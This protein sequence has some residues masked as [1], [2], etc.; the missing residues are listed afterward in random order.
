M[1]THHY[2]YRPSHH[3]KLRSK[4][5]CKFTIWLRQRHS[6]DRV[7]HLAPICWVYDRLGV[8]FWLGMIFAVAYVM[9]FMK[10]EDEGCRTCLRRVAGH[11]EL[12]LRFVLWGSL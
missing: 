9:G 8:P 6:T 11:V 10:F 3:L 12:G 1:Y 5:P 7:D 4:E 2:Y